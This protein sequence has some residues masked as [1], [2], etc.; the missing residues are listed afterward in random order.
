MCCR[1]RRIS[2]R[3]EVVPPSRIHCLP[4]P[5]SP[6]G[7]YSLLCERL[8]HGY[9]SSWSCLPPHPGPGPGR[10]WRMIIPAIT[11][12][13]RMRTGVRR[14]SRS[15]IAPVLVHLPATVPARWSWRVRWLLRCRPPCRRSPPVRS[16][17]RCRLWPTSPL[18]PNRPGLKFHPPDC[19]RPARPLRDAAPLDWNE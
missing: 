19:L 7:G 14:F 9:C 17:A 13:R 2:G 10:P 15:S 8:P 11:N 5:I 1:R 3:F 16:N 4:C 6:I 18:R 12:R